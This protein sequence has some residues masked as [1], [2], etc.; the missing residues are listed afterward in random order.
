MADEKPSKKK[1][2]T[3]IDSSPDALGGEVAGETDAKAGKKPQKADA[4][5]E[6]KADKK[7]E[8]AAGG[9]KLSGASRAASFWIFLAL[10]SVLAFQ[11]MRQSDERANE[12]HLSVF[13]R[14]IEA[15][16]ILKVTFF[17][18]SRVEGELKNT[19]TLPSGA[20]GPRVPD[21]LGARGRRRTGGEASGPG[22]GDHRQAPRHG[23]VGG[24]PGLPAVAPHHRL[25]D[26]DRALDPRA[27]GTRR[28]N[29]GAPGPS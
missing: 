16:N 4:K 13:H 28:S 2:G 20:D 29:L 21:Q 11:F 10:M 1:A 7:P 26:M 8:K 5:P 14:E 17:G 24:P 3:K 25:L 22:R 12:L 6:K 9:S 27:A 19:I 15:Q 23:L 18:E